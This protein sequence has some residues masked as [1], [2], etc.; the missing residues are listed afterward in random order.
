MLA[1][2]GF[3]R[4]D[5]SRAGGWMAFED[6]YRVTEE[7]VRSG[8]RAIECR[9]AEYHDRR[10]ATAVVVLN[11]SSPRPIWV[12]GWSK[13]ENVGGFRNND[14]SVY[15][16]LEYMDGTPLWGQTAPFAV[17]T[18]D[19]QMRQVLVFPAKPIKRLHVHA[20]FRHHTGTV[21][22]DDFS[23]REL[24]P[25][26]TF[27]GQALQA[28][29]LPS[30]MT[31]GWFVR[32]VAS[33]G[34]LHAVAV[35]GQPLDKGCRSVH[36]GAD[37]LHDD[38]RTSGLR[39]KD[40]LGRDRILSVYYV[41]RVP[42][43]PIRWW[44]DMRRSLACANAGEYANLT[45]VGV[46]ATG[47]LSLYPLSCITGNRYG[48][49]IGADPDD[50]PRVVRFGYHASSRLFYAAFDVALTG[51]NLA[52]S[53]RGRGTA[54]LRVVRG[55]ADPQWGFRS[56]LA[57]YYPMF[58]QAYDRRATKEGIWIPFVDPGSVD[59][60]DDFGIAYHEGDN[61]V[62]GDDRRDIWSFRYTEPMTWWMPMAPELPRTYSEAVRLLDRH[63]RGTD[64]HNRRL[65]QAVMHSGSHDD[66]GA[67]NVE[68]QNAPW[69]NGA[70]WV[71]NPNPAM[72]A[73]SGESTKASLSYTKELADRLYGAGS[74]GEL[75]GEYLDSI[76]GWAD[77]LDYRPESLRRSSVPLTYST[78]ELRPV[79]PTWFSVYELAR[80]MRD[81]LRRRGKLLMA[82]ATPWRI[83]AFA[84][85]LDVMGTET[86]WMPGGAWRPDPDAVF[87]LRRALSCRKPYLLLQNTDFD[88]FGPEQ[89]EKYF[90]RSMFYAVFPSMFS[91]D[92]ATRNYWTQPQWHNRDRH[93]FKKYIPVIS[94][95]SRAGWEPI[96]GAR[97][98]HE[99]V[100]VERY[101]A[102]YLTVLNDGNTKRDAALT[103][104]GRVIPLHGQGLRAVNAVTGAVV[105]V[106]SS[107]N[108][109]QI[110]VSL[111][112]EECV[113]L[114]IDTSNVS[115]Q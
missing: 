23:V 58:P 25:D 49:W 52:N 46:G 60:W 68:F 29:I 69:T 96:T 90:Q 109:I 81:D 24:S 44:S 86:N 107:R 87:C 89:V 76:E 35:Q 5:D 108:G 36:V 28:P 78:E 59:G 62:S 55:D 65:A 43:G 18:H 70:V 74:D 72:P 10:G 9:N 88:R 82:N 53:D 47:M 99:D 67:Y 3:E 71:L 64:E 113:A 80:F 100:Y 111:G 54:H 77:V 115:R 2:P 114:R 12:T 42:P 50:G 31:S 112:P 27:D 16:D 17:G 45:R 22:F 37:R 83:H 20:L 30:R 32:D 8:Q 106:S 110:R 75:D 98:D 6:G 66:R 63:L 51:R 7:V 61:S 94:E 85:L 48:R 21:W 101:G 11:Q 19:W 56:A 92:A 26:A 15:V 84:P 93:L 79:V 39:L 41:E 97:S 13:A 33:K 38:A 34:P 102:R 14:Y 57:R 4:V 1:N 73:P 104:D 40:T 95:L 103:L 91:V 105:P